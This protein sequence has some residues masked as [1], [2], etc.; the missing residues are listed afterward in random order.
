MEVK[1]SKCYYMYSYKSLLNNYVK[2]RLN[3]CLKYHYHLGQMLT[4][5]PMGDMKWP[6]G[7]KWLSS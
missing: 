3:F 4:W 7:H 6:A 5:G 1:T 2:P